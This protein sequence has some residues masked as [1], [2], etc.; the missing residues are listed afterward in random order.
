MDS[1]LRMETLSTSVSEAIVEMGWRSEYTCWNFYTLGRPPEICNT[2]VE[3]VVCRVLTY[4][5]KLNQTSIYSNP[6]TLDMPNQIPRR[7]MRLP[8]SYLVYLL[9]VAVIQIQAL[10][11]NII[12]Y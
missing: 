9:H 2:A 6:I 7:Q 12:V 11:I 1:F 4:D 5:K 3:V 8:Q 10:K